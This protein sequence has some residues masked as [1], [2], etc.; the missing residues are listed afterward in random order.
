MDDNLSIS[1][2]RQA[3]I[4]AQYDANS[5]WYRRDILGMRCTA[6][7]LIYQGFADHP[8]GYALVG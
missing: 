4:Q 8:D 2:E 1:P 5:V 6:E 3:A 7:G